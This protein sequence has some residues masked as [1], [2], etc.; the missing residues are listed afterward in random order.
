MGNILDFSTHFKDFAELQ[1]YANSQYNVIMELTKKINKMEEENLHL[2]D[3]LKANATLA[4]P[5]DPNSIVLTS[6]DEETICRLELAKL[7]S[8]SIG[9]DE[10]MGIEDSKKVDT[11]TKLLI[12]LTGEVRKTENGIDPTNINEEDLLRALVDGK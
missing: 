6:S 10:A 11:Y 1:A 9:S 12:A 3:L 4:K 2:K 7:K 8:K 5:M